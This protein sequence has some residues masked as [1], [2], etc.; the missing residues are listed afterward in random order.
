MGYSHYL[1]RP[2]EI[3]V[4]PVN[5]I[6]KVMEYAENEMGIKLAN[7]FADIDSRP[8]VD[9]DR[10]DFN[11]S[12]QQEKGV[13]TTTENVSL[14]WPSSTASLEEENPDPIADKRDGKWW[15][16]DLV[17]QRV[18]PI[19]NN[20][21]YGSGSYETLGIERVKSYGEPIKERFGMYIDGCK[22]SY[23]PY[24][25]VVTAVLLILKHYN[26]G[27][28]V[29]T[30]GEDKDW[31]DAKVLCNNVLGYGMEYKIENREL[32]NPDKLEIALA[33]RKEVLEQLENEKRTKAEKFAKEIE[34]KYSHLRRTSKEESSRITATKNVRQEL[35][36]AFPGIKFS[37]KSSSGTTTDTIDIS[38]KNGVTQKEVYDIVKKYQEGSFN[39]MEDIYES[40]NNPFNKLYG[41]VSYVFA[42]RDITP[43]KYQEVALENGMD[44]ENRNELRE[45]IWNK[46]FYTKSA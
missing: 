29:K 19:N 42:Q 18:A 44:P 31:F 17:S 33:E 1:Y 38:W 30:D 20:T 2:K 16:G 46:S 6:K 39:G 40:H 24:D 9:E 28:I 8:V 22:T 23:R 5:D 27:M 36:E 37:V 10:I 45:I 26:Q 13:W 15:A 25:L 4:F 14:A 32:V 21:G 34:E 7:G 43:D 11:G 12:E 41:G 3:K 35:K